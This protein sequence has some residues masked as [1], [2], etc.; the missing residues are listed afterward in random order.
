MLGSTIDFC[1]TA[2]IFTALKKF[3]PTDDRNKVPS[4]EI[5]VNGL[6]S[7]DDVD[8]KPNAAID[9]LGAA[10]MKPKGL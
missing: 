6:L 8:A 7:F 5:P 9:E 1:P 2:S 10:E 3:I 4:E